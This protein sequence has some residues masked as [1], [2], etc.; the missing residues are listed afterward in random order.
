[1][2]AWFR[3]RAARRAARKEKVK[4]RTAADP[5]EALRQ[6][7]DGTWSGMATDARRN[8]PGFGSA[9]YGAGRR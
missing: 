4:N 6:A 2:F 7:Q 1:M 3:E 8:H 5:S 9:P